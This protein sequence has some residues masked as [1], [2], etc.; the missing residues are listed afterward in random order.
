MRR[1]V[2]GTRTRVGFEKRT[3]SA[4]IEPGGGFVAVVAGVR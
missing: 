1:W 2:E 4:L 3:I